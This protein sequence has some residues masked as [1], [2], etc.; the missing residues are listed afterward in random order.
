[1]SYRLIHGDN[2]VVLKE[3]IE[4][5]IQV[6]AVVTDGPY[7]IAMMQRKWDYDVPSVEFW[8]L[9]LQILKPGG[10]VLS[11]GGTRTYHR[12]VVN[13]EDAGFMPKDTICWLFGQGFSKSMNISKAID[14]AAGAKRE[15]IGTYKTPEAAKWEGFGSA[16]K[17]AVELICLARR[18]LEEPTIAANVLKYGTG[19]LNI[20]ACRI[21][22]SETHPN[23]DRSGEASHATRYTENGGT[24]I[25]ALPGPRGGDVRGR[26]PANVILDEDAAGLLDEQTGNLSTSYRSIRETRSYDHGGGTIYGRLP[27]V[28]TNGYSDVGGA[29]RFFYCSKASKRERRGSKHPCIKPLSLLRYLCRLITPPGGTLLDPFAGSGTTGEAAILEGFVPIL[30]EREAE[31]IP[32]IEKRLADP[33]DDPKEKK[34]VQSDASLDD[35]FDDQ[36]EVA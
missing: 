19:G 17:P 5:G 2:L 7:G 35:M 33:Y 29:S 6:D 13:L 21:D 16:L 24:N 8:K 31:Y 22:S 23:K 12:M 25:A 28:N 32:D 3:L 9:V 1:M 4:E 30:I 20:D 34:H 14:K 27:E 18:P 26:F 36:E 11:F 15:V 10:H